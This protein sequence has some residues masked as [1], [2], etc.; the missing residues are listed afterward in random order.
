MAM[1]HE[2]L[3]RAKDLT[4]IDF[5]EYLNNMARNIFLDQQ[6]KPDQVKL[7]VDIQPVNLNINTAV[8]L[9]LIMNELITNTFKHAFPGGR[10]GNLLIS[11][12]K[13]E[14]TEPGW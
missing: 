11:L 8:P 3:Y 6:V 10:R 1:V 14:K 5:A 4:S 13:P 12:K 2:R 7:Q 9:G